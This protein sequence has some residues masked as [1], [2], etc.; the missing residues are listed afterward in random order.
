MERRGEKDKVKRGKEMSFRENEER[1]SGV[2]GTER[3]HLCRP[4][5]DGEM[6]ES[7]R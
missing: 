1:W 6:L 2:E 4:V 5:G 3:S 7:R